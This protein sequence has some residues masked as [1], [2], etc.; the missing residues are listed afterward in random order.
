MAVFKSLLAYSVLVEAGP[1]VDP[2]QFP[3][4]VGYALCFASSCGTN[5]G[6]KEWQQAGFEA[7]ATEETSAPRF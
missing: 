5:T 6:V 3:Y 7:L 2:N 1:H 4:G